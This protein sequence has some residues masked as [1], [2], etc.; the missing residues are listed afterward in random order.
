M[1]LNASTIEL[2]TDSFLALTNRLNTL[3]TSNT[4]TVENLFQ[5][6][7]SLAPTE[8]DLEYRRDLLQES[9]DSL[10]RQMSRLS[11]PVGD[12]ARREVLQAVFES[13]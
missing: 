7:L 2:N 8:F 9:V 12:W 13:V 6:S 5:A 1:L 3:K 11:G 4:K 10:R